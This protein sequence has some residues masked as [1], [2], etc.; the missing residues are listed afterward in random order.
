MH[1]LAVEDAVC[2]MKRM[3]WDTVHGNL[4]TSIRHIYYSTG[5]LSDGAAWRNVR[6]DKLYPFHVQPVQGLQRGTSI[7]FSF[8]DGCY[9]KLCTPLSSCDV[10]RHKGNSKCHV[11][12][13]LRRRN[14]P[15]LGN[16]WWLPVHSCTDLYVNDD[17]PN[18]HTASILSPGDAG[19][20]HVLLYYCSGS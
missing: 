14:L 19:K 4:A 6:E 17:D 5:L 15:R 8:L 20:T 16:W 11:S 2:E 13:G 10:V 9:A 7:V 3:C 18:E 12:P 1:L